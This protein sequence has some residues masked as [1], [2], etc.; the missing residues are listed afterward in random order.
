[1]VYNL[2]FLNEFPD[3]EADKVGKRKTF[4][5]LLGKEKASI[6]YIVTTILMYVWIVVCVILRI[7]PIYALIALFTIPFAIQA[8]KGARNY[9]DMK[10]L[11]PGLA[12]NVMVVLLTQLFLGIGYILGKLLG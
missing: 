6:N 3:V 2:L 11:V 8:I 7:M 12:S 10:K 4:L 9:N 1:L 5:I